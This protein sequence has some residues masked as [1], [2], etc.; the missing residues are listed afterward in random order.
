MSSRALSCR[1]R[2]GISSPE[3]AGSASPIPAPASTWGTTVNQAEAPGRSARQPTPPATITQPATALISG[4]PGSREEA[5]AAIGSTLT[6]RAAA[7]GSMLQPETS[8]STT[9][10]MTAVSEA[11]SSASATAG[12]QGKGEEASPASRTAVSADSVRATC[13]ATSSPGSTIGACAKKIARHENAWVSAPPSAGPIAIPK[14]DA[15][16]H[17]RRPGPGLPPSRS[18][19]A[20]TNPAAPPSAWTPR[21]TSSRPSELEAPQPSDATRNR[22]KPAA[23]TGASPKRRQS[24]VAG[25]RASARM[26]V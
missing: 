9:R 2:S 24:R 17:M 15:A 4:S 18:A 11:E 5:I 1:V 3:R 20:E 23:P 10:K 6:A 22:A 13:R 19:N 14:T 26:A 16:T 12:R 25:S 8:R 7:S 21:R